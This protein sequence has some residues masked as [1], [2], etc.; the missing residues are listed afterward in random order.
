MTVAARGHGHGHVFVMTPRRRG[1]GVDA[2]IRF[3]RARV[4]REKRAAKDS[5]VLAEPRPLLPSRH[6]R[7]LLSGSRLSMGTTGTR[8]RVG[9][10]ERS[11]GTPSG[12]SSEFSEH[13]LRTA[14]I[15]V[16][17]HSTEHVDRL[18]EMCPRLSNLTRGREQMSVTEVAPGQLR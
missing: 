15:P 6:A 13:L 10:G 12:H 4:F 9:R 18:G 8:N 11:L 14:E 16:H 17:A 2:G 3:P 1:E 7:I 5:T